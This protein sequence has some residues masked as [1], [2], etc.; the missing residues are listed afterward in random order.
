MR[1]GRRMDELHG[2][3][4]EPGWR[5]TMRSPAD[6]LTC[7][8]PAGIIGRKSMRT[9]PAALTYCDARDTLRWYTPLP[10]NGK[11]GSAMLHLYIPVPSELGYLS[12]GR[13]YYGEPSLAPR[14]HEGWHYFMVLDGNPKLVVGGREVAT[15]PG[16]VSIGDPVCPIG[17]SDAPGR[18][19]KMLTWIW[20]LPSAH[21]ALRPAQGENLLLSLE[22]DQIRR[23]KALHLQC[24]AAV[25][26]SN[27][28]SILQLRAARL[29]LDLCL[30][31]SLGCRR[32]S[33]EAIRLDLAVNYLRNH[34]SE[35]PIVRSLCEY[36]QVSK[37]S[38]NRLFQKHTSKSPR[39]YAQDLRMHWARE[40]LADRRISVKSISCALGYRHLPDFSRAFRRY[41]GISASDAPNRDAG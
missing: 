28:R 22:P 35:Q 34:V 13:R 30:L 16:F 36:L 24:R 3:W 6:R 25:A 11:H 5:A 17:H 31:E 27:E 4:R 33:N 9:M 20:R 21:S 19:C 41:F 12:W 2:P 32:E 38:L 39:E 15:R 10:K 23:L 14:G 26:E 29:L 1:P 18:S 40:Q 37:A 8:F 7:R